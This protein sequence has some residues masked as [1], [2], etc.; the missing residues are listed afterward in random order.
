[1]QVN[2]LQLVGIL[3]AYKGALIVS[4]TMRTRPALL[5][6]SRADSTPTATHFPEGVERVA[7][8]RHMLATN[9][10]SNVVAQRGREDHVAPDQFE[11]GPLWPIK[12][13]LCSG[14]GCE[15]CHTTGK[16]GMGRHYNR[17]LVVHVRKPGVFYLRC[18]PAGDE[19][20]RPVKIRDE[21]RRVHDGSEIEGDELADVKAHYLKS[22]S[23]GTPKQELAREIPYRG[24]DV[25][26]LETLTVGSVV[27]ELDHDGPK[28]EWYVPG[29]ALPDAVLH[30]V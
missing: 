26:A 30:P 21:W 3:E 12:C 10:E 29:P 28:P 13:P 22:K 1:M 25:T 19:H 24:Y 2:L 5:A 7:F 8:G 14:D 11:A 20:G 27:Y 18:R 4:A 9:Y 6:K 16:I 15:V 23:S 17:F